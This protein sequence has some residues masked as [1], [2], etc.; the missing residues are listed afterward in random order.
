MKLLNKVICGA[1]LAVLLVFTSAPK[2]RAQA[3][4]DLSANQATLTKT[5]HAE[6]LG[7]ITITVV[8]GTSA[9]GTVEVSIAPTRLTNDATSGITVTFNGIGWTAG[10][11]V[12]NVFP[13]SGLV[14]VTI[15]AGGTAGDSVV[16]EGLRVSVPESDTENLRVTI[17]ASSNFFTQT[18]QGSVPLVQGTADGLVVDEDSDFTLQYS[19]QSA[20][21][22]SE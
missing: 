4:F 1:L 10:P 9:A 7:E 11:S 19:Q 5:G 16:I 22:Q 3:I 12:P 2:A 15:P 13:D 20:H 14:V 18:G 8:S 6:L 21:R 17:S